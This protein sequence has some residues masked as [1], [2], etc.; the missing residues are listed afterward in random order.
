MREV[1]E[2]MLQ[3]LV[4]D[5]D[6]EGLQDTPDRMAKAWEFWT[7]GYDRDPRRIMTTF[8]DGAEECDEMILVKNIPVYSHCEHHLAPFYGEVH[9]AYIPDGKILGLSKFARLTDIYMRRLQVQERLTNQIANCIMDGLEPKGVAVAMNCAHTCMIG[10]GVK[11]SQSTT[12]TSAMR[13]CFRNEIAAR[14][15]FFSLIRMN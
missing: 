3:G 1:F 2:C 8:E 12:V 5:P 11:V 4:P 13:G 14:A 7:S 15:E 6:R 9:I 10:R